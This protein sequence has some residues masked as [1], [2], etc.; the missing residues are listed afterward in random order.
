MM[1]QLKKDESIVLFLKARQVEIQQA[2]NKVIC[3]DYTDEGFSFGVWITIRCGRCGQDYKTPFYLDNN[4]K[5]KFCKKKLYVKKV[6]KN[7]K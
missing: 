7:G 4:D 2:L 1:E 5:C 3:M 6:N